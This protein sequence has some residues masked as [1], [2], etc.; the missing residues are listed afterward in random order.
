[1]VDLA[2]A[3]ANLFMKL[4]EI[5]FVASACEPE[6]ASVAKTEQARTRAAESGRVRVFIA[7]F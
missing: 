1:M 3:L 4:A 6:G 7:S 5:N 2:L